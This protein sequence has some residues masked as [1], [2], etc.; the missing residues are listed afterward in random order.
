[1][2]SYINILK[3]KRNPLYIRNRSVPRCKQFPP[4]L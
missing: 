1:M 2:V 4:R 3:T